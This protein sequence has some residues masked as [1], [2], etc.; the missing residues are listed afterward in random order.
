MSIAVAILTTDDFDAT[1]VD[2]TTVTFEGA[3]ETHVNKKTGVARRHEEDVDGDGDID[4]VLH[5]RLGDTDLECGSTDGTLTG[6]TFDG[7]AIEG[8][9]AVRMID[10]GGGQA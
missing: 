1:S 4:L 5:F 6:E 2:H 10:E 8:V 3:S 9:D 7:Q